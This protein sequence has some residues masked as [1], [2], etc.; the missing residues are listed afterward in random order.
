MQK[1]LWT[2]P[3]LRCTAHLL[4]SD[5]L[6]H[7]RSIPRGK[8]HFRRGCFDESVHD[9]VRRRRRL[10]SLDIVDCLHNCLC[11]FVSLRDSGDI[12][13]IWAIIMFNHSQ[14]GR[15]RWKRPQRLFDFRVKQ[16][17]EVGLGEKSL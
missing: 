3:K 11:L 15:R 5:T 13:Q 12:G 16:H 8:I 7:R 2:R 14:L 17:A 1:Q 9:R 6:V 4:L 10:L